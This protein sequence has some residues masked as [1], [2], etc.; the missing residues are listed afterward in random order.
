MQDVVQRPV[1][2]DV[3]RDVVL[4]EPEALLPEQV[5]DVGRAARHEVVHARD[6]V[7]PREHELGQVRPEESGA[8]GDQD[9]RHQCFLS[10]WAAG[11]T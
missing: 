9:S 6:L 2:V 11:Q 10:D 3:V 5:R 4:D 1:D 8:A 7:P